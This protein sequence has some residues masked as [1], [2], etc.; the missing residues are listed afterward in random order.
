METKLK[1]QPHAFWGDLPLSV[2]LA[3]SHS[4]GSVSL[5]HSKLLCFSNDLQA[6][7]VSVKIPVMPKG[8]T[9]RQAQGR[10]VIP[11]VWMLP[12]PPAP[13]GLWRG[14]KRKLS[15]GLSFSP[16]CVPCLPM[17]FWNDFPYLSV[18]S[19]PQQNQN[20]AHLLFVSNALVS[21]S[22][23]PS[24]SGSVPGVCFPS[25]GIQLPDHPVVSKYPMGSKATGRAAQPQEEMES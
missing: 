3:A 24:P 25:C 8:P 12:L 19:S 23:Q 14:T 20:R 13:T 22:P 11:V 7:I 16:E 15:P 2:W 18:L 10:A 17:G 6:S 1:Q 9:A 5:H 4:Q 21:D